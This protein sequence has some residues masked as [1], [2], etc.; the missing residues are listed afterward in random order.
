MI[1]L[2][3]PFVKYGRCISQYRIPKI[4]DAIPVPYVKIMR[5]EIKETNK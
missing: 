4:D 2:I 1:K 3:L 5:K